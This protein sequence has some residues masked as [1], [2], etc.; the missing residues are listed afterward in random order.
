MAAIEAIVAEHLRGVVADVYLFGS[1]ARGDQRVWSD[2]DIAVD[3]HEPMPEETLV[4]LR[5]ALEE[6][7]VPLFVD[8]VDLGRVSPA[9]RNR[10]L[11]EGKRW[12][13]SRSA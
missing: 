9:F 6:C 7:S 3:A 1:R 5:G 11:S 2:V 12:T 8:V 13:V 10:V 4:N